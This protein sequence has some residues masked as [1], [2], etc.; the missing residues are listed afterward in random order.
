MDTQTQ[1]L[2]P[3]AK[4]AL[5][6]TK[7]K[8]LIVED[9]L[10]T[11]KFLGV[12]LRSLDFEVITA[13]D[14]EAG[15]KEARRHHPNLIILD[16]KL[17]KMIGEEVCKAIREDHDKTFALTPIIMLSGKNSDVDRV[18]GTVIGANC[19]VTKPFR[20]ESI[21]KEIHKFNL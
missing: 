20:I 16:L 4:T 6:A 11:N 17:P 7:K 5:P 2:S 13:Y 15:L 18:V 8:V 19:Y 12:R 1:A 10:A 14:G 9:D 3:A 21:L